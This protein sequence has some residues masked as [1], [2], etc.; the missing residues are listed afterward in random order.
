[1]RDPTTGREIEYEPDDLDEP[2]EREI[3]INIVNTAVEMLAELRKIAHR[4][5]IVQTANEERSSFEVDSN[6]S[7]GTRK[8][9]AKSYA[10]TLAAA[11]EEA[12]SEFAIGMGDLETAYMNGWKATVESLKTR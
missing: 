9:K 6:S 8:V 5:D 4:L 10:A 12:V 7:A 11:R 3:L 2:T 1:M